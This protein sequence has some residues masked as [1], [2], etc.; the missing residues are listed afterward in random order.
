[1]FKRKLKYELEVLGG[2]VTVIVEGNVPQDK[3]VEL[4]RA[5]EHWASGAAQPR[6]RDLS[7]SDLS[8]KDK[9]ANL[10]LSRFR[11]DWFSSRDVKE[12]YE[13]VYGEPIKLNT[14]STYLQRF[15]VAGFL[16]RKGSRARLMYRIT[17][18]M[19]SLRTMV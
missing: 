14:V 12:A 10:V 16:E 7:F 19:A 13:Q 17:S 6:H 2:R 3:V 5:I 11:D 15:Y 8:V 18:Q 4:L 9:I 1:M